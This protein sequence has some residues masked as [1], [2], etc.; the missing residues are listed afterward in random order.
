[1]KVLKRWL[2]LVLLTTLILV[3]ATSALAV[4]RYQVIMYGDRD[5]YVLRLQK[6]LYA[7][8]YLK[9]DPPGISGTRPLTP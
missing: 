5:A 7:R 2:P 8:G 1:M 3:W 6:E 9:E 4:E